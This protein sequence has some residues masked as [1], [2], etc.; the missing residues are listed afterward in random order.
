MPEPSPK[1]HCSLS[2]ITELGGSVTSATQLLCHSSLATQVVSD[3]IQNKSNA[4]NLLGRS[5]LT[6]N[7]SHVISPN[8]DTRVMKH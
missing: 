5:W 3:L 8:D 7:T 6:G 1:L 2:R 4:I